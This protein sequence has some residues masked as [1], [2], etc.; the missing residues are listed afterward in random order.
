[1]FIAYVRAD[2]F[3]NISR[4]Q[5]L[6]EWREGRLN[7]REA[8]HHSFTRFH[9]CSLNARS[10]TFRYGLNRTTFTLKC[11]N[12]VCNS[13]ELLTDLDDELPGDEVQPSV[14]KIERTTSLL[15]NFHCRLR[16]CH[17]PLNGNYSY[18]YKLTAGLAYIRN[19]RTLR[20]RRLHL[21]TF[22]RHSFNIERS[23]LFD[24]SLTYL[25][26]LY[27]TIVYFVGRPIKQ[28]IL[29]INNMLKYNLSSWRPA[30]LWNLKLVFIF[31]KIFIF[32]FDCIVLSSI[33]KILSL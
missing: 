4:C 24:V 28:A 3:F 5:I 27:R 12:K 30:L 6:R 21:K 26:K 29:V 11:H 33:L 2:T 22:C 14:S 23:H 19:L 8:H 9:F 32:N 10:G 17:L 7:F 1:M 16:N 18:L 15:L 13:C 25:L 20:N 31:K